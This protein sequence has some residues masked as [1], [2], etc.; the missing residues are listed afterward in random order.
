LVLTGFVASCG[1]IF[2]SP[3][4]REV[5][6]LAIAQGM[7]SA[8]SNATTRVHLSSAAWRRLGRSQRVRNRRL[9]PDETKL[10]V[11]EAK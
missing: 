7:F 8:V 5:L 9:A 11:D 4:G 6:V 3:F 10:S 2:H 1:T